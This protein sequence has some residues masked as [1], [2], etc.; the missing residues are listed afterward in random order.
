MIGLLL[1]IIIVFIPFGFY[2]LISSNNYTRQK[3]WN[4]YVKKGEAYLKEKDPVLKKTK[5]KQYEDAKS[6]YKRFV[7]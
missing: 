4:D 6:A 3:L 2:F 7:N 5:E 1:V